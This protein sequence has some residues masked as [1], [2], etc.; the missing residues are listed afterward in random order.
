[1]VNGKGLTIADD[2]DG[3]QSA[4][5]LGAGRAGCEGGLGSQDGAAQGEDGGGGGQPHDC[6]GST[7]VVVGRRKVVG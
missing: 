4:L 2:G 7:S 5:R 1:M 6:G 3:G